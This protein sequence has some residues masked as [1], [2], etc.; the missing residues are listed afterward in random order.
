MAIQIQ[1]LPGSPQEKY[2]L[3]AFS[4]TRTFIVPW[5]QRDAFARYFLGDRLYACESLTPTD[6]NDEPLVP[7]TSSDAPLAGSTTRLAYPGKPGVYVCQIAFEPFEPSSL[8]TSKIARPASTLGEY[9]SFAKAT[10][11]YR[12]ETT[13][14]D[15]ANSPSVDSGT[16]LTYKMVACGETI[17]L[18]T[19]GWRWRDDATAPV[20]DDL[21][22]V[23][24]VP[25]IEHQLV[26]SNVVNPPWEKISATQGT[27]NVDRFLDYAPGTLLFE[28]AEAN[29]I[30]NGEID[31]GAVAYTWQIRFL[32]REKRIEAGGATRGWNDFYRESTGTWERLVDAAGAP[33]YRSADHAALFVQAQTVSQ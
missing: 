5:E 3:D 12:A 15:R 30:F 20:A 6:D 33:L 25:T 14:V 31:A 8:D 7:P 16:S 19:R 1:E 29:K 10:V 26:W 23:K 32:F 24:R 18:A 4:A 17:P 21:Q 22:L 11:F 28:G 2:S 13:S 27:V 9:G